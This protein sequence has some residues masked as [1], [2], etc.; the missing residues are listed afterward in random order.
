MSHMLSFTLYC[1]GAIHRV[2][3]MAVVI[4]FLIGERA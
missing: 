3:M 2:V 1:V 4:F